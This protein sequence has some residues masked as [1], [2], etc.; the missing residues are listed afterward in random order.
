V[1]HGS[2]ISADAVLAS[3]HADEFGLSELLDAKLSRAA[4]ISVVLPARNEEATVAG[5]VSSIRSHLMDEVPL[6]DELVVMDSFS[7]DA[8]AERAAAAGARVV[9]CTN[10]LPQLP[11]WP[12]KGEAL[13]R[14]LFVTSGELVVFIDADLE[15][16]GPHFITGLLGPLL[17]TGHDFSKGFYRRPLITESGVS[18]DGG[19]RV[20]ELVARPLLNLYWPPLAQFVQP[21]AGEY[22]VRRRLLEQLS[23]PTGYGVEIAM[24]IDLL[25]HVGLRAMAQ[26]DLGR[27]THSHQATPA[28]GA[29]AA[30]IMGTALRRLG[31]EAPNRTLRQFRHLEGELLDRLTGIPLLER[32]PVASMPHQAPPAAEALDPMGEGL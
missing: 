6:V 31:L 4:T 26:V 16:A 1:S 28:L 21:L 8:T 27:R 23:F 11:A 19:G 30:E 3:F 9:S 2:P 15:D 32:P 14:S 10:V 25:G 18:P 22:A 17:T 20:T 24:L 12:G 7:T 13:W 29:M 5:I